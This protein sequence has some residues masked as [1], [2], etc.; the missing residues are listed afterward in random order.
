[1]SNA[2]TKVLEVTGAE[3]GWIYLRDEKE[4]KSAANITGRDA[5]DFLPR[6]AEIPIIPDAQNLALKEA[7]EVLIRLKH[8]KI[9][10]AAVLKIG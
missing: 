10:G 2:L 6:A 4:I 9:R 5:R 1:M 7:N 3:V 8:E